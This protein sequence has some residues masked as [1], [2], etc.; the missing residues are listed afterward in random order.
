M[1]ASH[2]RFCRFVAGQSASYCG[3]NRRRSQ[4]CML[5]GESIELP[6]RVIRAGAGMPEDLGGAYDQGGVDPVSLP[7]RRDAHASD[8]PDSQA[9]HGR[10]DGTGAGQQQSPSDVPRPVPRGQGCPG[11][12]V[13]T[14]GSSWGRRLPRMPG[15]L[16]IPASA[17]WV[18]VMPCSR[19]ARRRLAA[20]GNAPGPSPD[21]GCHG[22]AAS[23]ARRRNG[24]RQADPEVLRARCRNRLHWPMSRWR[25]PAR[26]SSGARD[27][28]ATNSAQIPESA[29]LARIAWPASNRPPCR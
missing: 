8:G 3:L 7:G 5:S 6:W 13:R 19:C 23:R 29:S 15:T 20:G 2:L 9:E 16:V 11:L 4:A 21:Q 18:M 10:E 12:A 26:T 22:C 28:R 25:H 17:A 1:G 27:R 14:S 24:S